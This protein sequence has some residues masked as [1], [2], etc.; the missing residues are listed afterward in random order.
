MNIT[1]PVL[2]S[3][4]GGVQSSP[5]NLCMTSAHAGPKPYALAPNHLKQSGSPLYVYIGV[6]VPG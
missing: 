5:L 1:E 4:L 3:P 6:S 2:L